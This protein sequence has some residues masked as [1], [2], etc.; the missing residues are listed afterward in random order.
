MKTKLDEALVSRLLKVKPDEKNVAAEAAARLQL[1]QAPVEPAWAPAL[2]R[3]SSVATL[4]SIFSV[5]R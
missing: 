1:P 5:A 3:V 4:R 2:P